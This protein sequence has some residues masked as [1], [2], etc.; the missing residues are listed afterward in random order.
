M[1]NYKVY[2]EV[3]LLARGPTGTFK[4]SE[5]T[6]AFT[7]IVIWTPASGKKVRLYGAMV[8]TTLTADITLKFGTGGG[9]TTIS[10]THLATTGSFTFTF[11]TPIEGQTN[12]VVSWSGGAATSTADIT[13]FGEEG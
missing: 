5:Q 4:T 6:G 8:S 3:P 13:L 9:A 12:Q 7:D 2:N 10:V 1:P 11:A